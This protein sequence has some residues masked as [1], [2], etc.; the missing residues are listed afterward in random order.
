MKRLFVGLL[1]SVLLVGLP[2][3]GVSADK[4]LAENQLAAAKVATVNLNTATVQELK[5]LPGV[6]KVTAEQ[7]FSYRE[8]HGKF[9]SVD[10]L[11]RVKGIGKKSL[12]KFRDLVSLE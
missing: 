12:E 1:L 10:E 7:I 2:S 6:G 8:E 9:S 4:P 5:A 3:L 11:L